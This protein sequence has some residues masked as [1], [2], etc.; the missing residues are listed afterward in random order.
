M[1]V[2]GEKAREILE[3]N[4]GFPLE[5]ACELGVHGEITLVKTRTGKDLQF[6]KNKD[7]R[8]IG[9]GN[10]LLAQNRITT[11]DEINTK[12]DALQN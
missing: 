6:T 12:I 5:Q 1:V 2:I 3:K 7:S 11:I 9:R 10:P 8:K 4:F